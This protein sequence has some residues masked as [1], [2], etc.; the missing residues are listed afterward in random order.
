M[1][2]YPLPV[3]KPD[4]CFNKNVIQFLKYLTLG[5]FFLISEAVI[6][7]NGEDEKA[8]ERPLM[9]SECTSI[10]VDINDSM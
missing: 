2:D 1:F 8:F 3:L 9:H 5:H 7:K 10:V 4:A 6:K